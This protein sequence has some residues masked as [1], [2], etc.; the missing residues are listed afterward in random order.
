MLIDWRTRRWYWGGGGG[1]ERR[2]RGGYV[3][4]WLTDAPGAGI[5]LVSEWWQSVSC[6]WSPWCQLT[7]SVEVWS[8][9]WAILPSRQSHQGAAQ[10]ETPR[11]TARGGGGGKGEGSKHINK[12]PIVKPIHMKHVARQ[13]IFCVWA[14]GSIGKHYLCV[15]LVNISFVTISACLVKQMGNMMLSCT[16]NY[17]TLFS[18]KWTWM[19]ARFYHRIIGLHWIRQLDMEYVTDTLLSF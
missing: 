3:V 18:K 13:M 16:S 4:C 12:S 19:D 11:V 7:H 15:S 14:R 1:R 10:G 8:S 9:H 2:E 17:S 5:V 6:M